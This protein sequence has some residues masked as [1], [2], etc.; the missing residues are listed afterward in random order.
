MHKILCTYYLI[1]LSIFKNVILK[2][3]FVEIIKMSSL[4][5]NVKRIFNIDGTSIDVEDLNNGVI[6]TDLK[7]II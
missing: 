4:S 1:L 3:N 7:N 2:G 5:R 6:I